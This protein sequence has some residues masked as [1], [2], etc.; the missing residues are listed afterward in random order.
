MKKQIPS[1]RTAE[2][3]ADMDSL[4]Y[5]GIGRLTFVLL[6]PL[7]WLLACA[8]ITAFILLT[9]STL[10]S[11]MSEAWNVG[12][13]MWGLVIGG[14]LLILVVL[15]YVVVLR[16]RNMGMSAWWLLLQYAPPFCIWIFWRLLACP[17]GYADH[18]CLDLPGKIVTTLLVVIFG[19]PLIAM[20][21]DRISAAG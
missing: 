2:Y 6:Y 13:W 1:I 16:M 10:L 21:F 15:C 4:R 12:A 8:A 5:P 11:L 14:N 17:E 20:L 9:P 19:L 3:G 18:K 7:A